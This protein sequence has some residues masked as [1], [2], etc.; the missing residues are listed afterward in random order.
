MAASSCQFNHANMSGARSEVIKA[1]QLKKMHDN[2]PQMQKI[3]KDRST[4]VNTA[5]DF[6][7]NYKGK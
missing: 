2:I 1:A 4:A 6:K 7:R 3:L 5:I